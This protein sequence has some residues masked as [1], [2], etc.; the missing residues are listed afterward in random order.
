MTGRQVSSSGPYC[1]L[2]SAYEALIRIVCACNGWDKPAQ[3][4]L[5][6]LCSHIKYGS[7]IVISQIKYQQYIEDLT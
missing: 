5:R 4:C 7:L 2:E 3:S 6:L 1:P